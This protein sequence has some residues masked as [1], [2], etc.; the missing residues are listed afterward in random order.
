MQIFGRFTMRRESYRRLSATVLAGDNNVVDGLRRTLVTGELDVWSVKQLGEI[1]VACR[2]TC[3]LVESF[4]ASL[5]FRQQFS[6][7]TSILDMSANKLIR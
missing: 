2:L 7:P 5:F 1:A 4:K 3:C 6:K